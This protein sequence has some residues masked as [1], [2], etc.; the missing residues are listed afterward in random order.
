MSLD[1]FWESFGRK[2]GGE[3]RHCMCMHYTVKLEHLDGF[4][5]QAPFIWGILIPAFSRKLLLMEWPS[6][7]E[8]VLLLDSKPHQRLL[9]IVPPC[10]HPNKRAR[11]STFCVIDKLICFYFWLILQ[12]RSQVTGHTCHT[13]FM[14][15]QALLPVHVVHMYLLLLSS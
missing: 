2:G 6:F 1:D 11:P 12:L 9:T 7:K 13:C 4:H 5:A 10:R 3:N 14:S 8:L 15:I